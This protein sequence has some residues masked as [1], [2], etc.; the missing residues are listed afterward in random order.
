MSNCQATFY[1]MVLPLEKNLPKLLEKAYESGKRCLVL[2]ESQERLVGLNSILWSYSTMAFLPHGYKDVHEKWADRQ[3]IW[4]SCEFENPN[5][6]T[7]LVNTC[8]FPYENIPLDSFE[9]IMDLFDATDPEQLS[10]A[11]QREHALKDLGTSVTQWVQTP[12]GTW[13]K[14]L[15]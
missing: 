7:I 12:K 5:N 2:V 11:K 8:G 14:G 13:E 4:L 3:P 6:S 9:R 10:L 15:V 1:G